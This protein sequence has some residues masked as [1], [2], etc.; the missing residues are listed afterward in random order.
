M[1]KLQLNKLKRTPIILSGLL[2]MTIGTIS[3]I[4]V[5][6]NKMN[7]QNIVQIKDRNLKE[8]L[9]TELKLD[10]NKSLTKKDMESIKVL[11]LSN[12]SNSKAK[13]ESLQGLEYAKNLEVLN[14]Q[15]NKIKKLDE[16]ENMEKLNTLNVSSNPLKNNLKEIRNLYNIKNV[17][18]VNSNISNLSA[19]SKLT[20]LQDLNVSANKLSDKNIEQISE[21]DNLKRLSIVSNNLKKLPNVKELNSLEKLD[22]RYNEIEEREPIKDK[23]IDILDSNQ[24]KKLKPQKQKGDS[25]TVS[26]EQIK[27]ELKMNENVK[28]HNITLFNKDGQV[29]E[30]SKNFSE[31]GVEIYP[32]IKSS[33]QLALID[34]TIGDEAYTGVQ[35]VKSFNF[36]TA[37][38]MLIILVP[39]V[40]IG[41]N[42]LYRQK[43]N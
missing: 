3:I 7:T 19:F 1:L 42:S 34:F 37:L 30:D 41:K 32:S 2:V 39:C 14:L 21:L 26:V 27:D 36:S 28:I 43:T 38:V 29:K 18:A 35:L 8:A 15:N 13:I 23:N 31:D 12:T 24:V 6:S 10:Y 25:I 33:K 9:Y 22:V 5:N 4:T 20:N 40:Y 16:L 17:V 11:D